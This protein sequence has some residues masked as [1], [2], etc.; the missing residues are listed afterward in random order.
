MYQDLKEIKSIV[1]KALF[2][3]DYL[4]DVI[5]LK[6]GTALEL[7][8][9]NQRASLD[10]DLSLKN[11]LDKDKLPEIEKSI[12]N[13]LSQ[14]FRKNSLDVFDVKLTESPKKISENK[15]GFWG[16]YDIEFKINSIENIDKFK[17]GLIS[18]DDLRRS[19]KSLDSNQGRK[20]QI[21]I[22]KFEFCDN[23]K[24]MYLDGYKIYIYTPIMLIYEKMRALCQQT[25]EYKS[26]HKVK[27]SPRPRDFYDIYTILEE[28]HLDYIHKD[29]MSK[30]N[31]IMLKEIFNIKKVPLDLMI[32]VAFQREFHRSEFNKVEDTVLDP[33]KL[34]SFDF[35]F[36]YTTRLM[37]RLY[38][39][40]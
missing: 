7:L 37:S 3:N 13:S 10:I 18:I 15:I 21:D 17:T 16:G 25:D 4:Y 11:D 14:V 39:Q 30:D 20:F 26:L 32:Q 29:L 24:E 36:D 34:E 40:M 12:H 2:S 33:A 28:N 1:I 19:S 6:G 31:L 5:V 23:K 27:I 35:Y 38:N 22:S 8:G 9:L